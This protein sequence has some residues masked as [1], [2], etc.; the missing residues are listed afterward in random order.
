LTSGRFFA[1]LFSVCCPEV[2]Q[3]EPPPALAFSSVGSG[4]SAG[5]L[6]S[7]KHT[8]KISLKKNDLR[9]SGQ[10]ATELK[11]D[12]GSA[13]KKST[14]GRLG[15]ELGFSPVGRGVPEAVPT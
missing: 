10:L 6:T 9:S 14:W 11:I 15:S 4:V 1:K 5:Q 8:K 12:L 2:G 3:T 7:G 13:R